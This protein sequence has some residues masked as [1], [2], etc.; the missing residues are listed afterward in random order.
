MTKSAVQNPPVSRMSLTEPPLP[1]ASA[2]A[3]AA[4]PHAQPSQAAHSGR[5][6]PA[7]TNVSRNRPNGPVGSCHPSSAARASW[8][9][10][11]A[12]IAIAGTRRRASSTSPHTADTSAGTGR[13]AVVLAGAALYGTIPAQHVFNNAVLPTPDVSRIMQGAA[14]AA[15]VLVAP[16]AFGLMMAAVSVLALRHGSLPRWLAILGFPLAALQ[17]ANAVAP[18]AAL[19][20]WSLLVSITLALRKTR[21]HVTAPTAQHALT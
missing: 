16:L 20:L 10:N 3:A 7:T 13:P 11:A 9:A 6:P 8:P 17:L 14:Y 1:G 2:T 4:I 21:P 12:T 19:V 15:V 18:M 5:R